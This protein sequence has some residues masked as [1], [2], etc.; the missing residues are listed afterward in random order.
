MS[1]TTRSRTSA[2]SPARASPSEVSPTQASI[3]SRPFSTAHSTSREG[4]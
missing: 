3:F 4:W 2:C 1:S